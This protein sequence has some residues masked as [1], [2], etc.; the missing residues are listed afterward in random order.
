MINSFRSRL[1]TISNTT[2]TST[3][4]KRKEEDK[5]DDEED[6]EQGLETRRASSPW[7]VSFLF[8]FFINFTNY[9]LQSDL[10]V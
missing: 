3:A 7:Y 1:S 8:L 6:E 2:T 10:Q 9:N 5:E 4:I